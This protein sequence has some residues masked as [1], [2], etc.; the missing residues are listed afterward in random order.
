MSRD[1]D[2]LPTS[3]SRLFNIF[4]LIKKKKT[5][6][7]VN[8]SLELILGPNFIFYRHWSRHRSLLAKCCLTLNSQKP[9]KNVRKRNE[10]NNGNCWRNMPN[11]TMLKKKILAHV[12][13]FFS[14]RIVFSVF[15]H[16]HEIQLT[17]KYAS[18]QSGHGI[19]LKQICKIWSFE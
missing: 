12:G 11:T 15:S 7:I 8:F 1:K 16:Y 18:L 10:I 4:S 14:A 17:S 6:L 5:N 3:V 19:G 13:K 2:I 9:G